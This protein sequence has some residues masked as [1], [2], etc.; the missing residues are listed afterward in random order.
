[1]E[2]KAVKYVGSALGVFV[3]DISL[4]NLEK[5]KTVEGKVYDE[6]SESF[7]SGIKLI[8]SRKH[9]FDGNPLSFYNNGVFELEVSKSAIELLKESGK[10][11]AHCKDC[12]QNMS[13]YSPK[14]EYY[15]LLSRKIPNGS[16]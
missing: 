13:I 12:S 9:S 3:S 11:I 1:M 4:E 15:D 10:G 2:L 6:C 16:E 8:P 7:T 5:G 14:Y